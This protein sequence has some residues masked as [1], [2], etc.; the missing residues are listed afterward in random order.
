[1]LFLYSGYYNITN[2]IH[3]LPVAPSCFLR[4]EQTYYVLVD[5]RNALGDFRNGFMD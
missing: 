3:T 2:V 4:E 5:M 1:M